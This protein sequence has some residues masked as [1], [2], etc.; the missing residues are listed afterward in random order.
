M[1]KKILETL[2]KEVDDDL[3][4]N[5]REYLLKRVHEIGKEL[6]NSNIK[7]QKSPAS[8]SEAGRANPKSK[9]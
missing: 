4:K 3:S 8:T 7:D 5:N 1:D 9:K 6:K 2:F